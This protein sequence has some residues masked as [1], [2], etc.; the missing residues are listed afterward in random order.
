MSYEIVKKI[1]IEGGKVFLTSDSNNV[2]PKD[3]REWECTSLS[4]VLQKEGAEAL[5]LR[6]LQNYE[7]GNFQEGNPNKWSTAIVRMGQTE[8]YKKYS[9][10]LSKYE[11]GCQIQDLRQTEGYKTLL[12]SSLSLKPGASYRVKKTVA[13]NDYYVSAVT[14]RMVKYTPDKQKSKIFKIKD[15][16]E[17]LT[18]C[19]NGL[20]LELVIKE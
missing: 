10:R 14:T 9:W 19:V 5:D 4:E 6:I 2:F 7:E 11:N 20:E 18:R 13:G 15:K 1:R 16:A 12:L 17:S 8:E 3:F